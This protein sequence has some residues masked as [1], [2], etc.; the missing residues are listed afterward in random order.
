MNKYEILNYE[1]G[2]VCI[3]K[4]EVEPSYNPEF[5]KLARWLWL[6]QATAFELSRED[7]RREVEIQAEI[8]EYIDEENVVHPAIPAVY[9]T[10]IHVPDDFTIET[11]NITAQ[12][13]AELEDRKTKRKEE[14]AANVITSIITII[15]NWPIAD[16]ITLL[17]SGEIQTV[18]KFLEY[19]SLDQSKTLLQSL[20][21]GTIFTQE[22]KD[23]ILVKVQEKIDEYNSI[24]W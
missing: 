12:Y 23:K 4:Q 3:Y 5:G 9:R 18:M 11:E 1:T 10:E 6:D 2:I 17:G 13:E 22:I 19:G 16:K 8:P 14:L 7:D 15:K 20:T 21:V 24:V